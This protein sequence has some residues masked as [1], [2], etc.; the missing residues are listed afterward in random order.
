MVSFNIG[1][2]ETFKGFLSFLLYVVQ[3]FATRGRS[4]LLSDFGRPIFWILEVTR[5][6]EGYFISDLALV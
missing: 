6:V 4:V 1:L 3:H 2:P 5:L